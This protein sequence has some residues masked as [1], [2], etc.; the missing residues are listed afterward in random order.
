MFL[1]MISDVLCVSLLVPQEEVQNE[2][3]VND[4]DAPGDPDAPDDPDDPDATAAN[5]GRDSSDSNKMLELDA[6]D[7]KKKTESSGNFAR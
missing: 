7:W 5:L 2:V 4:P 6:S 3:T 1:M